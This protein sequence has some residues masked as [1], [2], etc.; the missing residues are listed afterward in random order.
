MGNLLGIGLITSWH[1]E[2]CNLRVVEPTL[3]LVCG[4]ET[5]ERGIERAMAH[6]HVLEACLL[7]RAGIVAAR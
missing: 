2:L 3:G 6:I 4:V 1:K 7:Q 5:N